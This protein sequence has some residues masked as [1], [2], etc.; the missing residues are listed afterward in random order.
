LGHGRLHRIRSDA[1][2]RGDAVIGAYGYASVFL[3]A[4]F[5]VLA[6][7]GIVIA[8]QQLQKD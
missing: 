5:C 2:G 3:F 7:L 8:L 6:S 4:L 1:G